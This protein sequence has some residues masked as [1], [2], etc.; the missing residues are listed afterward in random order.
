M[1]K[2]E[3]GTEIR[4]RKLFHI[5]LKNLPAFY[6]IHAHVNER[7]PSADLSRERAV[8]LRLFWLIVPL[9]VALESQPWADHCRLCVAAAAAAVVCVMAYLVVVAASRS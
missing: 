2:I 4:R 3:G 9:N 1:P 8:A 6:F 5:L 7:V